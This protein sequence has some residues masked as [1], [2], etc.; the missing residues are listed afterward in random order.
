[1]RY[2]VTTLCSGPR[3][4]ELRKVGYSNNTAAIPR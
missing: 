2:D 4:N 3:E 1:V